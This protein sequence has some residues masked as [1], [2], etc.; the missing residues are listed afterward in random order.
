MSRETGRGQ[1]HVKKDGTGHHNTHDALFEFLAARAV[2]I[3]RSTSI[4][5]LMT[6]G[7][8]L[9]N[10]HHISAH[11][12]GC[13]ENGRKVFDIFNTCPLSQIQKQHLHWYREPYPAVH[14]SKFSGD[15][16]IL[17]RIFLRSFSVSSEKH[18]PQSSRPAAKPK[19]MTVLP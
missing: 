6:E 11:T 7:S 5:P 12:L 4:F 13:T 15:A 2:S 10:V 17:L 1:L 3:S 8:L 18:F 16:G 9:D 19:G 14:I